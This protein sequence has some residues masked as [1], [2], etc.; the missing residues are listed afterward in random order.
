ML[1]AIFFPGQCILMARVSA[2]TG[3]D[4]GFGR[5]VNAEMENA[6][7]VAKFR[8]E[9]RL[10][11]LGKCRVVENI[12]GSHLKPPVEALLWLAPGACW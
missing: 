3:G 11:Y 8:A 4:R 7:D 5:F 6:P 1:E 10:K 9:N 2:V 12:T